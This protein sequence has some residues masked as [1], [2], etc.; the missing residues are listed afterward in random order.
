MGRCVAFEL[1]GEIPHS[2]L[3][4]FCSFISCLFPL[5]LKAW[6][7]GRGPPSRRNFPA[8][9]SLLWDIAIRGPGKGGY[10]RDGAGGWHR[11]VSQTQPRLLVA[12]G[13]VVAETWCSFPF[14][15]CEV[16]AEPS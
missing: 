12:R 7:V 13:M 10:R 16:A 3:E 2:L 6:G 15:E 8:P 4:T 1:F 9:S 5:V 11:D 14:G